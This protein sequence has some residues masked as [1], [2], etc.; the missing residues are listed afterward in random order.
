MTGHRVPEESQSAV[1]PRF[2]AIRPV[3][4][5]KGVHWPDG[6]GSEVDEEGMGSDGISDVVSAA[7]ARARLGA[8]KGSLVRKERDTAGSMSM[9]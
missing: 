5:V 3:R 8:R 9:A 2:L 4:W 1:I 6:V 7:V